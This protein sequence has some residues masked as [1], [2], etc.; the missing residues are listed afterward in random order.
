MRCGG[1]G[2]GSS[3]APSSAVHGQEGRS[4]ALRQRTHEPSIRQTPYGLNPRIVGRSAA[5]P[6]E[7]DSH[8]ETTRHRLPRRRR[9]YV[10]IRSV[11]G[12]AEPANCG[13][14]RRR[15]DVE[16]QRGE[17]GAR[18]RTAE[19]PARRGL[20]DGVRS[21]SGL[22]RRDEARKPIRP[23]PRV[24]R[25]GRARRLGAGRSRRGG[26]RDPRPLPA[27]PAADRRRRV[28]R[29]PRDADGQCR[30]AASPSA[31]RRRTTSSRC[32]PATAATPRRPSTGRSA[33][34]CRGS[35]SCRHRRRRPRPRGRRRCARSCSSGR[36]SS[37]PTRRR[38]STASSTPRTS[39]R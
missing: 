11:D 17:R 2:S 20:S 35:G 6:T 30:R 28:H 25:S 36:R 31:R 3:S 10:A 34:C 24:R 8:E 7:G 27:R 29:V 18:V 14:S 13:A 15:T 16:H 22:R 37:A 23:V 21:G 5:K 12:H 19:G 33:P 1:N 4:V 26:T 39:T 9:D 32:G 38:P